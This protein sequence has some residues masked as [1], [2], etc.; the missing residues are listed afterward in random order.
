MPKSH[1]RK[2]GPTLASVE[3][4]INR[5][6]APL[7]LNSL[8]KNM[9]TVNLLIFLVVLLLAILVSSISKEDSI[10]KYLVELD[11]GFPHFAF[12]F[13]M[14]GV[15]E[16]PKFRG[17]SYV[18]MSFPALRTVEVWAKVV[19][20]FWVRMGWRSMTI[21][22]VDAYH[23]NIHAMMEEKRAEMGKG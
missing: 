8:E 14:F 20:P 6:M 1:G 13:W 22:E 11:Y 3:P 9:S 21:E 10:K 19:G 23:W 15:L 16:N 12:L 7:E 4:D 18:T 17:F 2:I 5:Y